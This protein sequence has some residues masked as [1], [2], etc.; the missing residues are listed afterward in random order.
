MSVDVFG[1]HLDKNTAAGNRGPPGVGFQITADGHYDLQNKRL[2]NVAEPVEQ[3]NAVTLKILR[4]K[5]NVLQKQIDNV[6]QM[7]KALEITTGKALDTFYADSRTGRDLSIRNA[8]IISKLDTRLRAL[9]Y[10]REKSNAVWWAVPIK[11]KS[12]DDVTKAMESVLTQGR[13]PKKLHVDRGTEFYNSK[14]ESLMSRY[15][16]K[17]YSTYSNLKASICE[18]FNRTLKSKM[19]KRF[20]MQGSYKWLDILSDLVSAYNNTKHRTIRLKQSDVI[21]A[22]ERLVLLRISKFKNV[23]EEGYTPN[24]TTE[25]FTI[26]QVE[27]TNPVT[28]KLK[29][30]QG[31]PIAGGFYEQGLLKVEYPDIYLVEKVLQKRGK[32]LYVKW[33]GFDNT[34]NSWINES[35]M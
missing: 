30:Y 6:D 5:F 27:N 8:E 35:D 21:I 34:H 24:W 22:N 4:R 26:I 13:V 1:R 9:E 7:I 11:S 16:I 12:G 25:I 10:E 18:Q 32:K 31:Q 29:D 3:N 15:E 2:C 17:L 14:F 28:Y 23:F 20:S 33:L 19:W